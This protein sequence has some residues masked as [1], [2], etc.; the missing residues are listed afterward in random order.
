MLIQLGPV[1]PPGTGTQVRVVLPL[2]ARPAAVTGTTTPP[3]AGL[4]NEAG[5]GAAQTISATTVGG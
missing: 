2:A 1:T 3:P 4:G 5:R